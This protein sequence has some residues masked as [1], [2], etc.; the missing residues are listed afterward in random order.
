MKKGW[1]ICVADRSN[2]D[3]AFKPVLGSRPEV[4]E[5]ARALQER[6]NALEANRFNVAGTSPY[7]EVIAENRIRVRFRFTKIELI[8]VM[9][10]IAVTNPVLISQEEGVALVEI[11][12][13]SLD[14]V[15][16]LLSDHQIDVD[17]NMLV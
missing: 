12:G 10:F 3:Q 4:R 15:H 11:D 16:K 9:G 6:Y 17:Q 5:K 7:A 14:R 1:V 8:E 13:T 2:A